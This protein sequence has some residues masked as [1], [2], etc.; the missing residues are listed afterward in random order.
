MRR[1]A[2]LLAAL[3]L[4]AGCDLGPLG[5]TALRGAPASEPV[6]DWSFLEPRYGLAIQ[7]HAPSLLPSAQAWFI[8]QDGVLWIYAISTAQL[9][10]PWVQRLRDEDPA[11]TIEVDGKLYQGKAVH[12][13]DPAILEPLLPRVL[14]KYHGVETARARFAPRSERFPDTQVRHAFFRIDPVAKEPIAK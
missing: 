12:V 13:T 11:V 2:G 14:R 9:E 3:L 6:S 10:R 8:V 5:G 1:A 7:T 4:A